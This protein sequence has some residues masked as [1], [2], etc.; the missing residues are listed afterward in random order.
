MSP[1]TTGSGFSLK[2]Q[3]FNRD[4]VNYLSSL[5]QNADSN[6]DG[7]AFT[8]Q[9]MRGLLDLELKQRIVHIAGVLETHLSDDFAT[10]AT[11]IREALPPPLDPKRTDDDF[12]DFIFA[13]LGEFVVRNGLERKQLRHSLKTLKA[14]TMRFSMED[15]IRAFIDAH[16]DAT[17]AE[18][19]KWSSDSN[20]H[21][22]RLVSEGTR[23]KLPWSRRLTIDVTT[24]LPFLETLHADPTRYVTR[25]VANHLNDISKSHPELVLQTLRGWKSSQCQTPKE[26]DWI[27]R[28]A[29]RT[30]I[31][32]GHSPALKFLGYRDNPKIEVS[33][34][35]LKTGE[36]RPGDTIEF[37][38]TVSAERAESLM[39]D[40]VIDFVKANG[41]TAP[42]VHKLKSL[43]LG[44][45]ESV[46]LTK[47]HRLHANATT[48]TLY[49]GRHAVTL[50]ING[51]PYGTLPF[52]LFANSEA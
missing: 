5:F 13:P 52:D 26:L 42:K 14:I 36:L 45:G 30:L 16:P 7:K 23:P 10:A 2:D 27:S 18:L 32:Q 38:F 41:T 47:R 48:Y 15:A 44:K 22:R 9:C 3:L 39:I 28:H 43:P 20:Y 25:S 19:S 37:S 8:R 12:G 29:L 1:S 11:Q 50:Q 49:P 35:E 33:D 6:F 17:L 31:K 34:F 51:K 40:Y 21:V 4:R 46:S 24:P